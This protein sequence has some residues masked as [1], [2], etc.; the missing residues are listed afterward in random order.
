MILY[1][2]N[3]GEIVCDLFLGSFSTAKVAIG[4]NRYAIGFEKNKIAYDYQMKIVKDLK[5][6]YLLDDARITNSG[7]N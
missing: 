2:S 5:P 4:L 3:E 7:R 1:S 6:G